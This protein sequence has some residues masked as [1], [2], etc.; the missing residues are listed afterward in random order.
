MPQ[1]EIPA[2]KMQASVIL[3]RNYAARCD[4]LPHHLSF[5][6]A[7]AAAWKIELMGVCLDQHNQMAEPAD[8]TE[9]K[10]RCAPGVMLD[11]THCAS[12]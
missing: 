5:S 8:D 9:L 7:T 10:S 11:L 6:K 3:R 4:R 12:S 1:S 2:K